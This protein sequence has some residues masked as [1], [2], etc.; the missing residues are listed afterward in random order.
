MPAAAADVAAATALLLHTCAQQRALASR[1]C[2]TQLESGSG[3]L[4]ERGDPAPDLPAAQQ[5]RRRPAPA[6]AVLWGVSRAHAGSS[7]GARPPARGSREQARQ[8]RPG[9]AAPAVPLADWHVCA[10]SP[11]PCRAACL[12]REPHCGLAGLAGFTFWAGKELHHVVP[13]RAACGGHM[14]AGHHKMPGSSVGTPAPRYRAAPCSL[15][16]ASL[17]REAKTAS[18]SRR[19]WARVGVCR[20]G[21]GG[22]AR[23]G[24]AGTAPGWADGKQRAGQQVGRPGRRDREPVR[25]KRACHDQHA[26]MAAVGSALPALA[27]L[28]YECMQPAAPGT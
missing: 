12:P 28:Q 19:Y 5:R 17:C 11:E 23:A 21:G 27:G 16:R 8:R 13:G 4:P 24:G 18:G 22:S 7:Q 14:Q 26:G 9:R 6:V 2:C 25:P 3:D 1:P 10:P 20:G 15:G